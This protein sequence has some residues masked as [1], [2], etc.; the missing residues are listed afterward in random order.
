[1]Y[2]EVRKIDCKGWTFKPEIFGMKR[3]Q[4]DPGDGRRHVKVKCW[5][6]AWQT[7]EASSGAVGGG[8]GS[9]G[10]QDVSR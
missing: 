3:S 5:E 8:Q 6:E 4:Q 9:K 7:L 1:M 2:K 10:A